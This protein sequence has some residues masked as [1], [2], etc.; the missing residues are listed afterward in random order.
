MLPP[1]TREPLVAF[2]RNALIPLSTSSAPHHLPSQRRAVET[3]VSFINPVN[4][5]ILRGMTNETQK[6][7][8]EAEHGKPVHGRS[9]EHTSELQSQR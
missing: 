7:T 5:E 8:F 1:N 6:F 2:V 3:Y 4:Y 9:E